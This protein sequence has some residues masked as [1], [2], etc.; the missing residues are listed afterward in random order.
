MPLISGLTGTMKG[1]IL[2]TGDKV[3]TSRFSITEEEN[4]SH[5]E[6]KKL[7][8]LYKVTKALFSTMD[9]KAALQKV[10]NIISTR[11]AM[12]RAAEILDTRLRIINYKIK[13]IPST[14]LFSRHL[15]DAACIIEPQT[16]PCCIMTQK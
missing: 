5:R 12:T 2:K 4:I 7:T 13:N 8:C 10:M 14:P 9:I 15:P 3:E 6:L 11:M 1:S 16:T